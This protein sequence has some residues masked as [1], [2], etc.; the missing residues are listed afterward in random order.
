MKEGTKPQLLIRAGTATGNIL[1]NIALV[2]SLPIAKAEKGKGV[3]LTCIPNPEIEPKKK[4]DEQNGD[5]KTVTFLIRVRPSD[6]EELY[7]TMMKYKS[8]N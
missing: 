4:E 7:D 6:C 5:K 2:E 8:S 3:M 1:L